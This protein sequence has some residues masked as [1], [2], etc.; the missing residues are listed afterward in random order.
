MEAV[1]ISVYMIRTES[2][3]AKRLQVYWEPVVN[4]YV[5]FL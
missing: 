5:S 3:E 4:M 2:I 1:V